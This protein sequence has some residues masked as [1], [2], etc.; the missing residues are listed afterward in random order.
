MGYSV[1][2]NPLQW[3]LAGYTNCT[4]YCCEDVD[5]DGQEDDWVVDCAKARLSIDFEVVVGSLMGA[6]AGEDLRSRG[7]LRVRE[8]TGGIDR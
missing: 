8:V 3:G 1:N 4:C 2:P 6:K 7:E 5:G